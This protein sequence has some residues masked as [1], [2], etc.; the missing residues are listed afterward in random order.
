MLVSVSECSGPS[1]FLVVSITCISSSSA[2]SPRPLLRHPKDYIQG[3]SHNQR[4]SSER[5][6]SDLDVPHLEPD[7][8][9]DE[10]QH[11]EAEDDEP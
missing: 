8:Q 10:H 4:H 2:W 11:D 5:S 7:D 6:E 3:H 9:A 1:T